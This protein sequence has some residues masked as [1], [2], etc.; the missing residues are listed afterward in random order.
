MKKIIAIVAFVLFISAAVFAQSPVAIDVTSV[1][2]TRQNISAYFS[3]T[4]TG[5]PEPF[6]SPL[7]G[8]GDAYFPSIVN[9]G[10]CY[11]GT[12]F[13][14]NFINDGSNYVNGFRPG[15]G[16]NIYVKFSASG[17]SPN[18][19]LYPTIPL[20]KNPVAIT[21]EAK[22]KGKIEIFNGATLLAYD[23][24]VDLVGTLKAQF[25]NYRLSNLNGTRRVFE[26]RNI[27]FSYS[28]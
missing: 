23:N 10:P 21:K 12:V 26:F 4:A 18:V 7:Q 14:T 2:I 1:T 27:A 19:I 22:T 13:P 9:C 6:Q 8:G 28:Q 16:Q 17:T 20:K 3:M 5:L 25:L 24:D 15:Y 11:L